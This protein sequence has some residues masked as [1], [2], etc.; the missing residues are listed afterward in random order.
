MERPRIVVNNT[1]GLSSGS[2]VHFRR[3]I[4]IVH[5]LS[6]CVRAR[7]SCMS[8]ESGRESVL[9]SYPVDPGDP[10]CVFLNVAAGAF[11]DGAISSAFAGS[12]FKPKV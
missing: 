6:V 8:V 10:T 5:I 2:S 3:H 7:A 11:T 12:S 1:S 9:S 4:F